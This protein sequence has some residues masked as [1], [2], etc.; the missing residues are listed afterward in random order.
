[1]EG[2]DWF[3]DSYAHVGVPRFGDLGMALS[4]FD[5]ARVRRS[6]VVLGPGVPDL[7]TLFD[8]LRLHP[9]RLR[10]VGIPFGQTASQRQE[11]VEVQLAAGALG[12]RIDRS[13]ALANP[14]VLDAIGAAGRWAYGIDPCADDEMARL[15]LGWLDRHPGARLAAPHFL[16][17]RPL[18]IEQNPHGPI[19][20]LLSHP[21]F[22]AIFSRHGGRGSQEPYP[23]PDLLPWVRQVV[24][25]TGWDRV[26]WG[27][28]YPVLYWRNETLPECAAW[29]RSLLPE[30]GGAEMEAFLRGNAERLFFSAPAPHFQAVDVPDWVERQFERNRLVPLLP[31]A[32]LDVPGP[33]YYS[34]LKGYLSSTGADA[35]TFGEYLAGLL[36]ERAAGS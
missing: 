23:H 18:P 16:S 19:A 35:R 32:T 21:R 12:I 2:V 27:S 10:G 15:Y 6:V 7:P 31:N 36:M 34:L 24:E 17:P 20:A 22:H 13:E 1:M 26:L 9:D 14:A 3:V 29:L 8:A 28:E 25:R 4:A 11:I 33:A 5:R 30:L